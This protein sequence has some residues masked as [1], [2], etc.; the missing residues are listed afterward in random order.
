MVTYCVCILL[1]HPCLLGPRMCVLHSPIT[2]GENMTDS[3]GL[4]I[5]LIK[6]LFK[7]LARDCPLG[8]ELFFSPIF[9]LKRAAQEFPRP[10]SRVRLSSS[11]PPWF[12]L[13]ALQRPLS[14]SVFFHPSAFTPLSS[15]GEHRHWWCPHTSRED[16]LCVTTSANTSFCQ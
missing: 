11:D 12:S 10:G 2:A 9:V 5:S 13:L 1:I 14:R 15:Q 4:F 6:E 3:Q 16:L 7:S 8:E